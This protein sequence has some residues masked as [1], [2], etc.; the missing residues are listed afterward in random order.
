[1]RLGR[2]GEHLEGQ[3]CPEMG[4]AGGQEGGNPPRLLEAFP[5]ARDPWELSTE[6]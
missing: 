1:M 4:E 2:R 3:P 5:Q 6:Q